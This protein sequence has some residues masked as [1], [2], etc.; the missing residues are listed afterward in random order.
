MDE[1]EKK[2]LG[3]LVELENEERSKVNK[4]RISIS[5]YVNL[6]ISNEWENKHKK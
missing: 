4:K 6:L 5:A 3:E 2:H 1:D